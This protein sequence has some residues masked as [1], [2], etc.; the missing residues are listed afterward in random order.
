MNAE[1][2][3]WITELHRR[4]S[5]YGLVA[6]RDEIWEYYQQTRIERINKYYRRLFEIGINEGMIRTD[7]SINIILA[8]YLNL[9]ELP[10]KT[11]YLDF[12][13]MNN[14]SIYEDATEVFLNGIIIK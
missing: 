5:R 11:E 3:E 12:L 2:E 4:L 1:L 8:V 13:E 10:L 7:L 6:G 9:M 14:Q